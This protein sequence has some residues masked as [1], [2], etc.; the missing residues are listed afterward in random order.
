MHS[1]THV[2]LLLLSIVRGREHLKHR[3]ITQQIIIPTD[4]AP[5][6]NNFGDT[7]RVALN[8]TVIRDAEL[9]I[10]AT[11]FKHVVSFART[12]DGTGDGY[13]VGSA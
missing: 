13:F 3:N 1:V 10:T 8:Y 2:L 7:F 9:V 11:T 6:A 5:F 4:M 12:N